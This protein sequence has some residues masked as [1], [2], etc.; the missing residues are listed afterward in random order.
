ME[1]VRVCVTR[2]GDPVPAILLRTP[3]ARPDHAVR[4]SGAGVEN[5][6]D[7]VWPAMQPPRV[8]IVR[9]VPF[10]SAGGEPLLA[11]LF[12]P[13]DTASPPP[14]I[15]WVHGGGWRFGSR[16]LAPDLSRFFAARGFA[17][18]AIDY[19]LTP[20]ATFPAQLEDLEAAVAWLPAA[21]GAYGFDAARVGLWGSSAGGHLAA[22][23][24]LTGS[25]PVGVSGHAPARPTRPVSAVVVGY[26][27][28]DFLQMDAHRPPAGT[29]SEDPETLPL[30]RLDMRSADA[31]SFESLLVGAPIETCPERVRRASPLTYVRPGAP[32]FLILHGLADTTVPPHQSLLLYEALAAHGNAVT[33]CVVEGLGHGFL[34]R[35]HLDD[36]PPRHTIC[37]YALEGSEVTGAGAQAIFPL[38]EQFFADHLRR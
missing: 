35:S 23:A 27:P 16:H 34:H 12:L 17:M 20:H 24:A 3:S 18:A 11:D 1:L 13:Q 9:D 15:V 38:V 4:L 22:L 7:I 30:P 8:R 28:V 2:S 31:D 21:A 6:C 5:T 10:A 25:H 14:V 33:L 37:R 19:R 26:A 29:V 32:P 36:G